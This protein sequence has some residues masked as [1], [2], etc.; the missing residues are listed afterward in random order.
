MGN[1]N[2]TIVPFDIFEAADGP[3]AICA[4]DEK[5]FGRLA[6]LLGHDE[7]LADKRFNELVG[8][9]ANRDELLGAIQK[10]VANR[11]REELVESLQKAGVPSGPVRTIPQAI[12]SAQAHERKMVL[13]IA[14]TE[15]RIPGHAMHI[16]TLSD[17]PSR[18]RA[19]ALGAD[20]EAIRKEFLD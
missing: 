4:P 1:G 18:P 8:R 15:M 17:D 16:S 11:T 2:P 7:W 14:G 9:I 10:A 3:L 13:E 6:G 5:S 19:A 12:E 20:S